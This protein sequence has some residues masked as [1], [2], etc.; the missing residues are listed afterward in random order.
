MRDKLVDALDWFRRTVLGQHHWRVTDP[1]G[2]TKRIRVDCLPIEQFDFQ[3]KANA[4]RLQTM[5][6]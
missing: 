5:N 1:Q 6:Q 2:K 3:R 4:A